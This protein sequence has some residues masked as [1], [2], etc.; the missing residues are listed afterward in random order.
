VIIKQHKKPY[1]T[2]FFEVLLKY[3]NIYFFDSFKQN[4]YFKPNLIRNK[5]TKKRKTNMKNKILAIVAMIMLASSTA[6]AGSF[7]VGVAGSLVHIGAEGKEADKNAAADTSVRDAT[8]SNNA[9]TAAIF[10]EYS[11]DNGFTLGVS[12]IPGSAD[13]NSK[14]ISK[15]TTDAT[16]DNDGDA[17]T[18]T[19]QAEVENHMTYYAEVPLHAGLFVK[20]GLTKMD[21]NTL[22]S[23]TDAGSTYGNTDVD[24]MLFGIGYKNTF[25][26]NGFYKV[27]G[28]HTE[29]DTITIND[30]VTD[31]G[32]KITAD[33][34]VTQVTFGIGYAF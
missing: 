8:A 23:S 1:F 3:S 6:Y 31:K 25:G 17:G 15:T 33:L 19:A 29:F 7:G 34:D 10:A 21:V 4:V 5:L 22:E 9:Y 30:S 32:N 27:E 20:G 16:G 13:I 24:G 28:T 12:H 18:N 26:N 11:F 14:K 2:Y